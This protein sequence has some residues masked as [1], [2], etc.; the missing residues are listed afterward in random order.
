MTL[1]TAE[2]TAQLVSCSPMLAKK[3]LL[4]PSQVASVRAL[5]LIGWAGKELGIDALLDICYYTDSQLHH[6]H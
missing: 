3:N 5:P 1:I 4:K 2:L 6:H